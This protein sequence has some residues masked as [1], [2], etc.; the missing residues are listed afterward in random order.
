M[1]NNYVS[2]PLDPSS[3]YGLSISL[4]G[5]SYNIDFTYNERAELYFISLFDA[6]NNPIVTGEAL[7]PEYP[8]FLDYFLPNLTGYFWLAR[9]GTLTGEPYK[10]FPD[11]ISEY[12]NLFYIYV[13]ED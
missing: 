13:T 12:Y 9:K 2:I 1:A 7:V 6:D 11:K 8:I 3:F 5:N 10:E 4:E